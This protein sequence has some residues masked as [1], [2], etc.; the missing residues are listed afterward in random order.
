[1]EAV[2]KIQLELNGARPEVEASQFDMLPVSP[3]AVARTRASWRL[4]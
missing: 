1:V 3:E 4:S 2:V